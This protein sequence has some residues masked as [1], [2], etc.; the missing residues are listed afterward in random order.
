M[1]PGPGRPTAVA[2]WAVLCV[3]CGT[4]REAWRPSWDAPYSTFDDAL[5]ADFAVALEHFEAGRWEAAW[6]LLDPLARE[7]RDNIAVGLWLQETELA[8]L[9]A[10]STVSPVLAALEGD[11]DP[12]SKLRAYYLE[13]VFDSPSVAGYLLAARLETDAIAALNQLERALELDPGCAWAHYGWAH[14]VWRLRFKVDRWRLARSSLTRALE[15]DPG[16]L[17]ARRLEGWMYA[18]EGTLEEAAWSLQT[19]LIETQGDPRVTVESR[20]EVELDMA[21][22]WI[23]RRYAKQA[24]DLLFTLQGEPHQRARRLAILAVAEHE[25]GHLE[26]ALDAARRAEDA[27]PGA[28]LPVVQQALIHQ[29]GRLDPAAATAQWTRVV[30]RASEGGAAADSLHNLR[31]LVEL[32]RSRESG[33]R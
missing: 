26:A 8:L 25:L 3:A 2:L 7:H 15:L 20:V 4:T 29:F 19:W 30:E 9:T 32:E 22:V 10:G 11:G 14:A 1:R 12:L 23:Q 33:Q 31:A 21:L 5:R 16:H 18:Q 13:R 27:A 6:S 28:L 24:R 17:R